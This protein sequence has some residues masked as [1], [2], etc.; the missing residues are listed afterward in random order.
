MAGDEFMNGDFNTCRGHVRE[1]FGFKIAFE[2][3][4]PD[5]YGKKRME[6]EDERLFDRKLLNLESL[7]ADTP[8]K[9]PSMESHLLYFFLEMD[10]KLDRLIAHLT[11]KGK[12]EEMPEEGMG[13]DLSGGG[14]KMRVGNP[15]DK[16]QILCANLLL[17]R[18]P[19]VR[20][21]VFGEVVNVTPSENAAETCF[22]VGVRFLD[23]DPDERERIIAYVFQRQREVL[24]KRKG[25]NGT[26]EEVIQGTE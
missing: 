17:S 25:K 1:S 22:D 3:V 12:G 2:P 15:L 26:D 23:L 11:G 16:G 4:S 14:M 21:R 5:E 8:S 19:F 6:W 7:D 24:R 13:L 9:A 10:A 18:V 20:V